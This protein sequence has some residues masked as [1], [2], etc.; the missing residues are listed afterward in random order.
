MHPLLLILIALSLPII[1]L[2]LMFLPLYVSIFSALYVQYGDQ[3]LPLKFSVFKILAAYQAMFDYWQQNQ[4]KLDFIDYTLPTIGLPLLGGISTLYI[5][6]K[7]V[8]YVRNI[9]RLTGSD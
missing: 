5:T 6:Y 4:D 7:F 8:Q 2:F 3:I 9:F 1:I